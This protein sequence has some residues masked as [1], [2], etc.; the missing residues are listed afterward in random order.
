MN[1]MGFYCDVCRILI[2]ARTYG[3]DFPVWLNTNKTTRT[4]VG[5]CRKHHRWFSIEYWARRFRWRIGK[6]SQ[7][8]FP[9][10]GSCGRCLTTWNIIEG[11]ATPYCETGG[12]FP[13]CERCWA[14]LTPE[15]RLPF[16]REL[17]DRWERDAK[18]FGYDLGDDKDW[19]NMSTNV[20]AGL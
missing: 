4:Q 5:Y 7:R 15:A 11:H 9:G 19:A 17:W 10:S 1:K 2:G 6:I 16:Y 18:S 12:C 13:L 14:D 3:A 20:L 8:L